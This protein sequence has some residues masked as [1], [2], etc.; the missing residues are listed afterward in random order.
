MNLRDEHGF[1]LIELLVG[2][3]IS[4]VLLSA[5]LLTFNQFYQQE[6]DNNA[7]LDAAEVARNALDTQ[8]RQ[9][10]NLAKRLNNQQVIDSIDVPSD[11]LVFQT[12]D[13][14]RTWVRY[15]LDTSTAPAS[16]GRGRLWTAVLD[17]ANPATLN[18]TTV[19]APMRTGCPGTG[20]TKT[21]VVGDH[22]TNRRVAPVRPLFGYTCVDGTSAC[23]GSPATYDQIVNIS[24]QT[25][26]DTKPNAGAAELSVTTR[27]HLRNQNQVPVARITPTQTS[28]SRTVLLNASGSTDPEGRTMNYYWFKKTQTAGTVMPAVANINCASPAPTG[29]PGSQTLWGGT[30]LG[31]GVTLTHT[32]A[33]SDGAT[34]AAANIG[35]V[36]CDPGDRFGTRGILLTDPF[37]VAIPS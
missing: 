18:Q 37:T 23:I 7:R 10:R 11:S 28:T 27:V 12:S 35:V 2:M 36:V 21:Q 3:T 20:W 5:A 34:N 8:A 14:S 19:T 29:S 17:P 31:E 26:V 1:T 30:Y 6:H 4:L 25:L 13:P 15:C 24:S 16:P 9:L 32:F 22:I 33:P